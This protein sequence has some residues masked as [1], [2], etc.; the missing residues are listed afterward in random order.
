M[1]YPF[2]MQGRENNYNLPQQR[3]VKEHN[4]APLSFSPELSLMLSL[5]LKD[6]PGSEEIRGILSSI[7]PSLPGEDRSAVEKLLRYSEFEQS[8]NSRRHRHSEGDYTQVIRTLKGLSKNRNTS[9]VF[10]QMERAFSMQE[11][12]SRMHRKLSMF[13]NK[14]NLGLEE[15]MDLMTLF[16]PKEQLKGMGQLS[17]MANMMKMFGNMKNFDPSMMMNM[18]GGM[19]GMGGRR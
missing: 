19:G 17:N 18:M 15:M 1:R 14:K 13:Q 12:F 3:E 4:P 7:A 10:D 9:T 8:D 6:N 16:M 11:E 2:A 5:A